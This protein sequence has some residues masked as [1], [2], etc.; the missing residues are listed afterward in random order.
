M[1]FCQGFLHIK[2]WSFK[3]HVLRLILRIRKEAR[4]NK[5]VGKVTG[6]GERVGEEAAFV[7]GQ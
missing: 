2:Y 3:C 6:F 4:S 7:V 5:R 1:V